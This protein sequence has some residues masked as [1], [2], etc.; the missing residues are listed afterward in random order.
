MSSWSLKSPPT[1]FPTAVATANGWTNPVTG[2]I[3]V[4]LSGLTTKRTDAN[5]V[6]TFTLAV[7]ANGTYTVGQT[8]IFT[9]TPSEAVD[10]T[11]S[12]TLT[13]TIGATA[14]D[15]VYDPTTSTSTS[16]KFKYTIQAGEV[17]ANGIAAATTLVFATT[18]KGKSKIVDQVA[19]S[20]GAPVPE[21][22]VTFAVPS[23]V[24]VLVA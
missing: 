10:V 3:L 23:L 4:W 2:E 13:L 21:A 1:W 15:A 19:D 17:D 11:G 24:A 7:P 16:L 22:S 12:P 9:L 5:G 6:P 18:G 14:R 20:T 8:L